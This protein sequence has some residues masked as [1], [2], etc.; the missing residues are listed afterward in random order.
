MLKNLKGFKFVA[1]AFIVVVVIIVA[2]GTYFWY[3]K[4]Q[5]DAP[6]NSLENNCASSVIPGSISILV[7]EKTEPSKI[8]DL[9]KPVNGRIY[10]N[11]SDLGIYGISVPV[12][13]EADS[14]KYLSA[15]PLVQKATRNLNTFTGLH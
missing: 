12:G 9:I 6:S 10:I 8:V 2:D 4:M 13:Q 15:Q 11:S 14:I 5:N 3:P 7:P 1:F